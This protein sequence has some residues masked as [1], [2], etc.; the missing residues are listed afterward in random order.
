VG[1][2]LTDSI[3]CCAGI[4]PSPHSRVYLGKELLLE[5]LSLALGEEHGVAD[6]Y[7]DVGVIDEFI[8]FL[9]GFVLGEWFVGLKT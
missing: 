3:G 4:R 1:I 9:F 5:C 6:F 2:V 7:L 8:L